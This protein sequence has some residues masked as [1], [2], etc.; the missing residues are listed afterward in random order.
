MPNFL[1]PLARRGDQAEAGAGEPE[2]VSTLAQFGATVRTRA[3]EGSREG[4]RDLG[5]LGEHVASVLAASGAAAE[6]LR[7]EA[8]RDAR[9]TRKEAARDAD[10]IRTRANQEAQTQWSAAKRLVDEAEAASH[11]VR[12]EADRYAHAR[13]REGYD[14]ASEIIR[15]AEHRAASIAETLGERHRV[16]LANIEASEDR[17]REL[18]GS[19]GAVAS[20]FDDIV[21]GA[22]QMEFPADRERA[23]QTVG[24]A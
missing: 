1:R 23:D 13:T 22:D 7:A 21:E 20:S 9:W 17:L 3:G 5:A 8:E 18:A 10:D 15:D 14:Q 12:S 16:V 2:A 19:L 11:R 4:R 6:R 24:H